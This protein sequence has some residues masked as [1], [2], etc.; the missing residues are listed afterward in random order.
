MNQISRQNAQTNVKKDFYKLM[1][2]SNF[3]Y[4]CRNNVDNCFFQPIYKEIEEL[5][6]PKRYQNVFDQQISD[7]VSTVILKSQIEEEFLNKLC[8]LDTH[9]EFYEAR[10]NS[11]EI[12]FK[13]ELEVVFSMKKS[14]QKKHKKNSIK[15]IDQKQRDEEKCLKTTSILEL[16]STLACSAKCLDLKK[17]PT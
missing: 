15:D 13:K 6:Y 4:D 2:N 3:G 12:F 1:N 9:D 10:K 14:R 8:A 7:F 16:D 5:S 11:L 17:I